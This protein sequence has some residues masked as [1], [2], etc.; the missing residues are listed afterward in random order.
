[1]STTFR[2]SMIAALLILA[3]CATS[4][5]E[6]IQPDAAGFWA[7]FGH[8]FVVFISFIWSLFDSSVSIF[9]TPNNGGWYTFG[10]VLGVGGLAKGLDLIVVILI[11]IFE[12]K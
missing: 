8:G 5:P 9:A 4:M 2:F 11:T 12:E 10:F 7:G 3:G 6:T 1:M